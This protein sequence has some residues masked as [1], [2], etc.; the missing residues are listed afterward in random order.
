MRLQRRPLKQ[1]SGA[2]QAEAAA[3]SRLGT[4]AAGRPLCSRV[5]TGQGRRRGIWALQRLDKRAWVQTHGRGHRPQR[6]GRGGPAGP[7]RRCP[8]TSP[9]TTGSAPRGRQSPTNSRRQCTA[10]AAARAERKGVSA[11]SPPRP[12]TTTCPLYN[13]PEL[14]CLRRIPRGHARSTQSRQGVVRASAVLWGSLCR[15]R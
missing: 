13:G 9:R 10:R 12:T 1:D 3:A 14:P 15:W 11:A 2:G 4:S 8:G 7:S 6:A 5:R